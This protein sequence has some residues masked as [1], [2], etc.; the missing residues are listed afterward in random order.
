MCTL[1]SFLKVFQMYKSPINVEIYLV[2]VLNS[3]YLRVFQVK[4]DVA[5]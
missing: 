1:I 4:F 5:Y 3:L 2:I